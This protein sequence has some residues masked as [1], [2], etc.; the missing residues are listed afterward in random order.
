[1]GRTARNAWSGARARPRRRRLEFQV[2]SVRCSEKSG[3]GNAGQFCAIASASSATP[4][5]LSWSLISRR[6][7]A[8]TEISWRPRPSRGRGRPPTPNRRRK[9]LLRR[10]L[11]NLRA[12]R[13]TASKISR[14]PGSGSDGSCP[15]SAC[16]A[17]RSRGSND[18]SAR[19]REGYARHHA[20]NEIQAGDGKIRR[21][22]G[23]GDL[24]GATTRENAVTLSAGP[25]IAQSQER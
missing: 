11:M 13:P 8:T 22:D 9:R 1:M 3:G 20:G 23:S 14:K 15:C 10:T 24:S 12:F 2:S 18:P 25:K 6:F 19:K 4:K 21:V 7:S 17:N 16:R 5:T